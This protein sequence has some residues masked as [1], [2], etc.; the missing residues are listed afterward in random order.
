M[1]YFIFRTTTRTEQE[2]NIPIGPHFRCKQIQEN[3]AITWFLTNPR[4]SS[5]YLVFKN[6]GKKSAIT[7]NLGFL[8]KDCA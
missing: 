4:K 3:Q 2:K 6:Q 7:R 8:R 1:S 5:N